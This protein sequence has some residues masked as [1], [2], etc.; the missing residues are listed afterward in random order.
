ME[1][2]PE[3]MQSAIASCWWVRTGLTGHLASK[4]PLFSSPPFSPLRLCSD[5]L[6]QLPLCW[7]NRPQPSPLGHITQLRELVKYVIK[8]CVSKYC[9]SH[10]FSLPSV[11]LYFSLLINEYSYYDTSTPIH[12]DYA[13]ILNHF[14][15]NRFYLS[16]TV[17]LDE[18][19]CLS[20]LL[21]CLSHMWCVEELMPLHLIIS[22][23]AVSC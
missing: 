23:R 5:L 4:P 15:Y 12:L 21:T 16:K 17:R 13:V 22:H 18:M 7:A 11:C 14:L 9:K 3:P 8:W 2:V 6:A 1:G 10:L 20:Y 19:Q